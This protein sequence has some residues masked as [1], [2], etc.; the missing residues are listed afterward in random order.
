[1]MLEAVCYYVLGCLLH[2][3]TLDLKV[4]SAN[5]PYWSVAYPSVMFKKLAYN[6]ASDERH[7]QTLADSSKILT[8]T[9]PCSATFT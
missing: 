8:A 3:H 4:F 7:Q 1:V 5:S 6:V 2:S 9:A